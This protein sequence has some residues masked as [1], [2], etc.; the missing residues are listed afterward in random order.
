LSTTP[1]VF[2]GTKAIDG[3]LSN[4]HAVSESAVF[5]QK[6]SFERMEMEQPGA[7]QK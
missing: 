6:E 3:E 4:D 5:E 1:K 7:R 2:V